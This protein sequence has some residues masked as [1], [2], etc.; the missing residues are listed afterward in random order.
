MLY[1]G[2]TSPFGPKS[3]EPVRFN[4]AKSET[5][6]AADIYI[7]GVIGD[8]EEGVTSDQFRKDL[9]SL[10][11][12]KTLNVHINSIGGIVNAGIGIY[13]HLRD[14]KARKIVKINGWAASIAS[15]VAMIGDEI[16]IADNGLMM[17]HEPWAMVAGPE[18]EFVRAIEGLRRTKNTLINT[19]AERTRSNPDDIAAMMKEQTFFNAKEAVAAGFAD[20]VTGSVAMAAIANCELSAF[21]KVPQWVK[22]H[23][24]KAKAAEAEISN[25]KQVQS[26]QSVKTEESGAAPA[27]HPAIVR[28]KADFARRRITP[29]PA[30]QP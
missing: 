4:M 6:N 2:P 16:E 21:S 13:N 27:P 11:Q 25:Q 15:Y 10:G 3:C 22:D 23:M 20:R 18:D 8:S 12:V 19:Y 30:Q 5:G 14:H 1:A 17:I 9:K 29:G 7:D 24:A 28:A 26:E